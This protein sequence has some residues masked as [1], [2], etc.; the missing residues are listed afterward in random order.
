[1]RRFDERGAATAELA[2]S[3]PLLVAL[4]I[5]LV[6]LLSIGVAQVQMVDAAREAARA[7]ARGDPL[8]EA[9]SR[10]EQV[11]PGSSVTVT[12]GDGAAVATAS[13]DVGPPGGLLGFL[14]EVR[15]HARAVTA[16]ESP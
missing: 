12:V 15:L 9:V 2:M 6:W 14:P 11:A 13:G 8:G 7:A 5:G 16:A 3:I 4:T 10:G 1:M